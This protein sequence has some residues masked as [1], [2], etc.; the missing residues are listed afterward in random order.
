MI[1]IKE[2]SHC[3]VLGASHK[4][5]PVALRD[6]LGF[7][8]ANLDLGL[9]SLGR[10]PGLSEA[11]ILST[12][13]RTEMYVATLY[14][15]TLR[16]TLLNWW[17]EFCHLDAVE[18]APHCFYLT[19]TEAVSHLYSVVSSVDSLVLG[20]N[21]ILGQV[22]EAFLASQKSGH[23]GFFLN[24]L[25]QTA[26]TLGKKVRECTA[27]GEGTVSI[28][29]AAVELCREQ[30]GDLSSCCVGILGLGEMGSIAAVNLS[31]AGVTRFRFFNRTEQKSADFVARFGGQGFGIDALP[32]HLAE[33]D[34]LITCA[35]C[36][37]YLVRG[38]DVKGIVRKGKT[39]YVDIGAPR[40]IAPEVGD[41]SSISLFSI[42]DLNKVVEANRN[43]RKHS[44]EKAREIIENA[45]DEFVAWF[46]SLSVIPLVLTMREHHEAIG[47]S[48]LQKWKHKVSPETYEVLERFN[49]DLIAKILH[50]PSAQIKRLGAAGLGL[51]S[52]LILEKLFDL[53]LDQGT[54]IG[55][56]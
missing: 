16:D 7:P 1:K 47:I 40:N 4:T 24:H 31:A 49:E 17:A 2:N 20:E 56:D 37:D 6:R 18:L 54:E 10:L 53:N 23:L 11:V 3:V 51:E 46:A 52:R 33:L 35:Q 50:E 9:A 30:F 8:A 12:C 29:F 15:E 42:D 41:L 43:M 38:S 22:R 32:A 13:N 44:A 25:F 34:V 5:C 48:V 55:N 36:S 26:M 14:P 39:V 21:Q 19:H 28:P 45:V 27:I